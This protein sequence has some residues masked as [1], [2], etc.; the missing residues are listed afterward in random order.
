MLY[1]LCLTSRFRS[2]LV[3]LS[4]QQTTTRWHCQLKWFAFQRVIPR[5]IINVISFNSQ[6]KQLK[7][8]KER[9]LASKQTNKTCWIII[10]NPDSLFNSWVK[11][12]QGQECYFLLLPLLV[13]LV[14]LLSS[15]FQQQFCPSFTRYKTYCLFAEKQVSSFLP[16]Q[17][18]RYYH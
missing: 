4:D 2:P 14:C 11:Q 12:K 5:I 7:R 13:S 16:I 3:G 8:E 17:T 15:P 18:K 10:I 6:R 1:A 9:E